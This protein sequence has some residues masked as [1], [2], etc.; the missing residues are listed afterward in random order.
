MTWDARGLALVVFQKLHQE[1]GRIQDEPSDVDLRRW[2]QEAA[3]LHPDLE[4]VP[5]SKQFELVLRNTQPE[6]SSEDSVP[7]EITLNVQH[8]MDALRMLWNEYSETA[9]Q[10]QTHAKNI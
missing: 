6:E 2:I 4:I 7:T 3:A 8:T 9:D 10:P 1:L 5:G